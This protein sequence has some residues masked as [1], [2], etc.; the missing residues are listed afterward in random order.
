MDLTP[1]ARTVVLTG[2]SGFVGRMV[3]ARLARSGHRVVAVVRRADMAPAGAE[4]AVV[5]L[6]ALDGP[7]LDAALP[8]RAAALLHLA[9]PRDRA[10][11]KLEGFAPHARVNVVATAALLAWAA[12]SGARFVLS[13]TLSVLA[14]T[15][16]QDVGTSAL[17]D[18]APL[19]AAP[20][21][22]YALT[23]RWAEELVASYRAAL[24]GG[25]SILRLPAVYGPGQN[26]YR[27]IARA[28]AGIAA[29]KAHR[30]P[31]PD[32]NTMNPVFVDDVADVLARLAESPS[33]PPLLSLGGPDVLTERAIHEAVAAR[34][35]GAARFE[36]TDAAPIHAAVSTRAVD[37]LFPAR[38]RTP[39]AEGL[40]RTFA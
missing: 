39:F 24:P 28:A 26:D 19:V 6:D 1:A 40:R 25:A 5:D 8:G 31:G 17:D 36:L 18:D 11:G 30:M 3:A 23:K 34:V 32:G 33:A 4:P 16:G 15:H 14:R 10:Q 9:T 13:S 29:G 35:G 12:R 37:A 7:G 2:A 20:A 22:A 27:G 38:D 21:G